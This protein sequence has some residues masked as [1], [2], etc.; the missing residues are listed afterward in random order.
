M[1]FTEKN[2]V[3]K[4]YFV[5]THN[6][7]CSLENC[8]FYLIL[9]VTS[10]SQIL[11]G[12]GTSF[13]IIH[14]IECLY[15]LFKHRFHSSIVKS[16]GE[17]FNQLSWAFEHNLRWKRAKNIPSN[18]KKRLIRIK[19]K[20]LFLSSNQNLASTQTHDSA[21]LERIR[22]VQNSKYESDLSKIIDCFNDCHGSVNKN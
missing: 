9:I 7:F 2:T 18:A 20:R 4:N 22:K 21:F 11:Q 16:S 15:T 8:K 12:L 14:E 13:Y 10:F 3:S 6:S 19:F 1:S 5:S 17:V